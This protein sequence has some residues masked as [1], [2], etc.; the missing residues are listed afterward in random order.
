MEDIMKT[1]KSHEDSGLLL[2]GVK[3]TFQNEAK[4]QK[5]GF[6]GMLLGTL[7]VSLLGN[8]LTGKGIRGQDM[9]IK[10]GKKLLRAGYGYER[11][12]IKKDF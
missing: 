2:K 4:E 5:G 6:L 11:F 3:E 8:M 1:V 9:K 7:G 10:K 12:L